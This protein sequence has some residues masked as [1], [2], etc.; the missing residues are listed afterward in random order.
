MCFWQSSTGS[1][2]SSSMRPETCAAIVGVDNLLRDKTP[3]P[4]MKSMLVMSRSRKRIS[5]LTPEDCNDAEC[6]EYCGRQI[7]NGF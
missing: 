7:W 5:D 4:P 3:M 1:R 6:F 2:M